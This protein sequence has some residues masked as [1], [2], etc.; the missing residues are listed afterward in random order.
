MNA[1]QPPAVESLASART[2]SGSD[3][4]ESLRRL[5]PVVYVDGQ[6]IE[7]VADAP[8]LAPGVNALAYSYDLALDRE[9]RAADDRAAV[10]ARTQGQ[11]DAAR[12]RVGR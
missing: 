4:R 10:D 2:M 3:Y 7:S 8:V 11:P 1:T 9:G 12:Q 5:R 6:R